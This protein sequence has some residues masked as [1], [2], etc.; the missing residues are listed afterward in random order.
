MPA[1]MPRT[2]VI[3]MPVRKKATRVPAWA[4]IAAGLVLVAGLSFWS[5]RKHPSVP[6]QVQV[7]TRE[8]EPPLG[9]G[10]QAAVQLALRSHKLERAPVLDR[11][12]A[13][14]GVL[15]G[16]PGEART[17]EISGPMGTTVLDDRPTFRWQAVRGATEYVVSVFDE[18]FQKLIESPALTSAEWRPEQALP[19]GAIYNWQVTAKL[20]GV[21]LRAPQPPAPEARFEVASA[22]DAL[23]IDAAR[24]DHPGNHLLLAVLMAK[25]GALDDAAR[26]V[27][28][29]AAT[30]APTAEA[31]R[32]SLNEIRK[33]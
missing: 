27:D 22:A 13:K 10:Q 8:P 21:N 23:S 3:A 20:G 1:A 17:F 28:A 32:Q 19:R 5:V 2:T 31:L 14:R 9:P 26:E 24:R 25:A 16:V 30:D 7:Q 4:G 33:Q 18:K 6:P 29:L 15:L 11:L 12:I